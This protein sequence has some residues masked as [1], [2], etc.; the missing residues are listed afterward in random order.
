[1]KKF[2][3]NASFVEKDNNFYITLDDIY[4]KTP[5]QHE[6]IVPKKSLAIQICE[7]WN[8]QIDT[9][10]PETMPFIRI[11]NTTIDKTSF[12]RDIVISQLVDYAYHD[13]ICYFADSPAEL[14]EQQLNS[15]RPALKWIQD[16]YNITLKTTSGVMP[17]EQD[18]D[19]S[20]KIYT[21]LNQVDN[22]ELTLLQSLTTLLGSITLALML[23]KKATDGDTIWIAANID[24]EWNKRF[25]GKDKENDIIQLKRFQEYQEYLLFL[26]KYYI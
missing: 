5:S 14:Q 16:T 21:I 23:L 2:Y 4:I 6:F 12:L 7:E 17:I 8:A 26:N 15:W 13:L 18:E 10:K 11:V 25:W 3:H 19:L 9:I 24:F 1:M 22:Y 20:D